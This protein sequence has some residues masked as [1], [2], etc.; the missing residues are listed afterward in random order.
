MEKVSIPIR[1]SPMFWLTAAIIGWINSQSL[2]G[3]VIWIVIIFVSILVHEYGHALMA[4]AFG[5]FPR[6]ELVAFGG[7]TYPEGPA[8]SLG[9]EFLVV[10]NG[11]LF[12]F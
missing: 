10:L 7:V 1:I 2:I 5:Q 6:I 11:P 9:K 8:I 4:R 12:S 3:T